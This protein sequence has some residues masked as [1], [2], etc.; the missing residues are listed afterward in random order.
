MAA[1]PVGRPMPSKARPCP[2]VISRA[3]APAGSAAITSCAPISS[4]PATARPNS[5]RLDRRPPLSQPAGTRCGLSVSQT[6]APS[7]ATT[8][9][10]I[11]AIN[12]IMS[13]PL[14]VNG[15][16]QAM[17][18]KRAPA[19]AALAACGF[20]QLQRY[21]FPSIR[22]EKAR[23]ALVIH[24]AQ[25]L[26]RDDAAFQNDDDDVAENEGDPVADRI[27]TMGQGEHRQCQRH[28]VEAEG[29]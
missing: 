27:E 23:E 6:P 25:R 21:E 26:D 7:V 3:A 11:N 18:R 19:A 16:R 20:L 9:K 12:P 2:T 17:K 4:T 5:A 1:K 22:A 14:A 15:R 28:M 13:S 10:P 8:G 24:Q 29:R